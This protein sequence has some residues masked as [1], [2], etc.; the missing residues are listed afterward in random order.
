MEIMSSGEPFIKNMPLMCL[1]IGLQGRPDLLVRVDGLGSELGPFA[2]SV[3]EIKTV[4]NIQR[5]HVLQGAVY[6]R[7]IGIAQGHEPAEFHMIN[8]DGNV[9]TIQMADV[10]SDLDGVL[11]DMRD[12]MNGKPVEP[13]YGAGEWPWESHVNKLA[14]ARND[15]SLIPGI[16]P[17]KREGLIGAGI[18]TVDDIEAAPEPVLTNIRGVGINTARKF[19]TSAKAIV[20]GRPLRREK[21]VQ[22][23]TAQTEVFVDLEGTDSR[24]GTSGPEVVN[25]LIGALIRSP[26]Q[27]PTYISF[28]ASSFEDE[29]RILREF[30]EWGASIEDAIFC[31]WH[32]YERT[33]LQKM[34]DYYGLTQG[35]VN[36][37]MDRLVDLHPIATKAF[38]FPSYSEGL[39]DI[40]K[41]LGFNWRQ[42]DVTALTSVA[43]YFEYL[44]SHGA[45][46]EVRQKI[47][48]YNEDDCRATMHV[49]DWLLA[50]QV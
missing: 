33:H 9:Q 21:E 13:C 11:S 10:A 18:R 17:A 29:E 14:I 16:G 42:D 4:R 19:T 38:A 30:F 50:Q 25:Y 48:D 43:L 37:V 31:H 28:F 22:V 7:L 24:I 8:R 3:V 1:S 39:K 45:N 44:D 5:A 26:D 20:Q 46:D 40:A 49:H 27:P 23:P 34:T 12:I 32:N 35:Q 47:V 15:I 41:S 2:Y 6:N 36:S